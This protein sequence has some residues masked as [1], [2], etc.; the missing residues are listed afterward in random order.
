MEG[1]SYQQIKKIETK[2]KK[3]T[4]GRWRNE[5]CKKYPELLIRIQENTRNALDGRLAAKNERI[6]C[7]ERCTH[8]CFHYVAVSLAHG[9]VIV[10]RLYKRKDLLKQF[11]DNHEEWYRK[12]HSVA[13]SMDRARNQALATST[14]VD[15]VLADTRPLSGRYLDM[16]IPCPFLADDRCLI[17]AIRPLSCSGQYSSSPPDWCAC[18]TPQEPVIHHMI[19]DDEDLI[20]L[21]RLAADPRLVLYELT[22]PTM[23]YRLLTEGSSSVMSGMAP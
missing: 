16:H 13:D 19:P 3:G 14:P 1:Q 4:Y 15:R 12:G 11:L 6:T 22:L 17:Y 2:E 18:D 7:Q 5:F 23:I 10:D 8:C 20:D 21:I 9:I